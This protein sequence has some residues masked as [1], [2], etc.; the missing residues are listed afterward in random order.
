[1]LSV[2]KS[3]SITTLK[4][5]RICK[6][7]NLTEVINLGIHA[8][9]GRF[10][11]KDEI[12]PEA[13][14]ILV[15]CTGVDKCGLLQ[16]CHTIDSSELY[17]HGYGYRSGINKTMTIHLQNLANE[18]ES[19]VDLNDSDV[20]LDIGSNDATLLKSYKSKIKKI[21]ID[22]TGSEFKQYYNREDLNLICDYFTSE[23]YKPLHKHKIITSVAMFYDLPDPL[24]FMLDIKQ[25]LHKDGIWVTEQSY[26]PTMLDKF[27][28]DTIC[29]E[30]LEYYS[31]KQIKWMADMANLKIIDVVLNDSNGG[32]FRVTFSHQDSSH[33][34]NTKSINMIESLEFK[35]HLD[36]IETYTEW[37]KKC[38]NIK[39]TLVNFLTEQKQSGKIISIYGAS[40]KGNTLLQYFGINNTLI[41]SVAEK[42]TDK[43]GKF[44]PGTLIPITSEENVRKSNPHFM[45]VLPWHFKEEFITR[46]DDYLSSGGQLIFPLPEID[47]V[48][49]KKKILI[50]GINGQIG[51]YLRDTIYK[52]DSNV[53]IYGLLNKSK[54]NINDRDFYFN[55]DILD[56]N[57]IENIINLIK[58]DEIYNLVGDSDSRTSNLDPMRAMNLNNGVVIRI[59]ETIKNIFVRENGFQPSAEN[60]SIKSIKLFN[61]SSSEIYRGLNKKIIQTGDT[62]TYPL[63]PYAISKLSAYW[64]IK[65]YREKYG[66]NCMSGIIFTTESPLRKNSFLIKKVVE[67]VKN[68]KNGLNT[69]LIVNNLTNYRDWIHAYD[70]ST[71]IVTMMNHKPYDHVISMSKI[72]SVKELIETAFNC[73]GINLQWKYIDN[74]ECG[75]GNDNQIYVTS[76]NIEESPEM[77]LGD[78]TSLKNI[79]WVPKYTLKTLINDMVI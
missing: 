11:S 31:F 63:N 10:P 6:N 19:R 37:I 23:T 53:Q 2:E 54:D 69:E 1:M 60:I 52:I 5:C 12:V 49:K 55:G 35:L 27:S 29:H 75:I 4:H 51:T 77:L 78:N 15:K 16:L 8:L 42:N 56:P 24:K 22:P 66:L 76:K 3:C 59:C 7:T 39:H 58:P 45:L 9:S 64:T 72:V 74:S 61:A 21:G 46:E 20:I 65:Y 34:I 71:A 25:I 67:T 33:I 38:D 47:I 26:M 62:S 43:F 41:D 50:T 44:T 57:V 14:L 30:H 13:P 32:S 68:I 79:G 73:I 36:R 70:V 48:T 40:T 18:I 17:N 28:F